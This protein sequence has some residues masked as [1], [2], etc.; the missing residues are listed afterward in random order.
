VGE[1][2]TGKTTAVQ[3]ISRFYDVTE[4]EIKIGGVN[5]KDINYEELLKNISIVF[6]QSFLTSGSVFE[7]IAM[8]KETASLDE[9]REVAKSAQ[10]DDFIMRLPDGYDTLV[11]SYSGRFSGGEKQRICIARAI[12]KNAPILILDEATSSADPE[13]QIEID[14]AISNLCRGKTVIIVAHRLGI[15]QSCD[16]I[17]VVEHGTI[18]RVGTWDEILQNSTYFAKAWKDYNTAREMQYISPSQSKVKMEGN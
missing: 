8:G 15:V 2:G 1:S 14:Q 3:L 7:N 6:Q 9:V 12:L 17:A 13:N 4:G 18:E 5:V 11:G 16:R 10:I